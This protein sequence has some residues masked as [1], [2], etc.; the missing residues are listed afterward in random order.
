MSD[1]NNEH[2]HVCGW[3][4]VHI[5]D[6]MEFCTAECKDACMTA[7]EQDMADMALE[8]GPVEVD[9]EDLEVDV[10][11]TCLGT[12]KHQLVMYSDGSHAYATTHCKCDPIPEHVA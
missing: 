10:C 5:T 11:D 4:G 6:G 9:R 1:N 2:V 8:E 3:C 12:I 7:Y